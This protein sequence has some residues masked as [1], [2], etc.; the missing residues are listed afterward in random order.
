LILTGTIGE[1]SAVA[2]AVFDTKPDE[3]DARPVKA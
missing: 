3:S 1:R 2:G